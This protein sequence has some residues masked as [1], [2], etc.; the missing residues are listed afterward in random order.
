MNH[1]QYLQ[2][3]ESRVSEIATG[4]RHKK[5]QDGYNTVYNTYHSSVKPAM[6]AIN[7]KMTSFANAVSE[8]KPETDWMFSTGSYFGSMSLDELV[9]DLNATVV[10]TNIVVNGFLVSLN[11][12]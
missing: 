4:F 2:A 9:I 10:R 3:A 8:E 1:E 5:N 7:A 11:P 12:E 6:D